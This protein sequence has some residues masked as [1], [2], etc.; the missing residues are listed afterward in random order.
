ML[1][2]I[3]FYKAVSLAISHSTAAMHF[4]QGYCARVKVMVKLLF[5]CLHYIYSIFFSRLHKNVI[6]ALQERNVSKVLL[7]FIK[8][9][10]STQE[11]VTFQ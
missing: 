5:D 4:Y 10:S 7:L 8:M 2:K 9:I 11:K 3:C 6:Q 1:R